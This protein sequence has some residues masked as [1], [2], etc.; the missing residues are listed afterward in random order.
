MKLTDAQKL[1][2][3]QNKELAKALILQDAMEDGHIIHGAQAVNAQLP[4]HLQK[5]TEDFDIYAKGSE[6]QAKQM[7]KKLDKAYDGDYFRVEKG[8]H[9]GTHKVKSNVTNKTVADYTSQG[10]KPKSITIMGN[11]F[12]TLSAMKGKIRKTLRDE[13]QA[14]RWDKDREVLQRIQLNEGALD[15]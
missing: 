4:V 3:Y 13:K 9:K 10:K 6:K 8:R 5:H 11:K 2:Y 7:E 12:A 15:W 1:K 14:F